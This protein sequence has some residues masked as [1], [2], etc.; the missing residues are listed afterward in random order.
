MRRGSSV[1]IVTIL[2][3]ERGSFRGRRTRGC[4]HLDRIWHSRG[5]LFNGYR[6]I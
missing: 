5:L 3:V 4:L 6:W 2:L 1:S